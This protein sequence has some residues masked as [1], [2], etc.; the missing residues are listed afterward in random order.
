MNNKETM[1]EVT[2]QQYECIMALFREDKR[3][4]SYETGTVDVI[5]QATIEPGDHI[6]ITRICKTDTKLAY[7][8]TLDEDKGA[9]WLANKDNEWAIPLIDGCD[10]RLYKCARNMKAENNFAQQFVDDLFVY[11]SVTTGSKIPEWHTTES[12]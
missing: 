8:V 1:P 4:K 6:S 7:L 5:M 3:F 2:D 11:V 9:W 12:L 10:K